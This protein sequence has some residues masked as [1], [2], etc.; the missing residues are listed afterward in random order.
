VSDHV[1]TANAGLQDDLLTRHHFL[2]RRLHSLTG[3]VPVGLF[4]CMHLFTNFQLIAGDF[5]HEVNFIH[6]MPALL[7][8]EV[9][10]WTSIGFHAALGIYYTL[11][12]Q[13]N[14]KHYRYGD[15]WRYTLQRATGIIAL[16]F[17]FLHIATLRWRWT[18]GGAFEPF[19]T[20]T[21]DGYPLAAATTANALRNNWVLLLYIIGAFSVVFHWAN[22]LWTAGITWGLTVSEQAQKR[23]GYVC[24]ALGV[25]LSL[26]TAG[27]IVGARTYDITD[28][29][30]AAIQQAETQGPGHHG[31]LSDSH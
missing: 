10:I 13:P 28:A 18:F 24:L 1:A 25:S 14:V 20:A 9:T 6:S 31:D 7:L 12:A 27:A 19:Y 23:W 15:N 8:M 16:I 30:R 11:G 29:D 2:L 26:F 4:V 21:K 5:Q 3:I 22:G 17:I